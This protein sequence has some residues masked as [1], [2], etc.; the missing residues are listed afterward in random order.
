MADTRGAAGYPFPED[1][2]M[3]QSANDND[4]TPTLDVACTVLGATLPPAL[5][6][7]LRGWAAHIH[8]ARHALHVANSWA[9]HAGEFGSI[10][11]HA[12]ALVVARCLDFGMRVE[13]IPALLEERI[14]AR[15]AKAAPRS[16]A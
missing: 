13:E 8:G 3:P 16:A 4:T 10:R 1:S 9:K 2:T 14:R 7:A 5:A 12:H 15:A 11:E 6:W